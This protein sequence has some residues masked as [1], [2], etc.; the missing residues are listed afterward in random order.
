MKTAWNANGE[1]VAG[2]A[3][4]HGFVLGRLD[5]KRAPTEAACLRPLSPSL[6][7]SA[8]GSVLATVPLGS[9]CARGLPN[10]L[11]FFFGCYEVRFIPNSNDKC[12]HS[13]VPDPRSRTQF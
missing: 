3:M 6:N 10:R 5:V 2:E 11:G 9:A 4:R 12:R 8:F 13:G 7:C 1:I